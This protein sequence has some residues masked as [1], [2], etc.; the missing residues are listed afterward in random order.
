M[1][2]LWRLSELKALGMSTVLENLFAGIV[3]DDRLQVKSLL[4]AEPVLAQGRAPAARLYKSEIF[5]WLYVGDTPLHLA[6]AGYRVE[7]MQM[8]LAAGVGQ[9]SSQQSVALCRRQ[10]YPTAV[11]E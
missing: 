2:V 5:H 4:D 10:L 6:A 3:R 8:L 7:I 1:P 11:L 9:P